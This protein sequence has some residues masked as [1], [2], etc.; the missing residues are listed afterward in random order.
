MY[1][2]SCLLYFLSG[3]HL[4]RPSS[5]FELSPRLW[6]CDLW[7]DPFSQ[8]WRVDWSQSSLKH[9]L[10][11]TAETCFLAACQSNK[12]LHTLE[13]PQTH[14]YYFS[15]TRCCSMQSTS[16]SSALTSPHW[17]S[18]VVK[19]TYF[20]TKGVKAFSWKTN[21][22]KEKQA[23]Y[24]ND[25]IKSCGGYGKSQHSTFNFNEVTESSVKWPSMYYNFWGINMKA[26][27]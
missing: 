8:R 22:N 14:F 17:T 26:V 24:P 10:P 27:Y 4:T 13:S 3:P 19:K 9:R 16:F 15:S 11:N 21:K 7:L 5:C 1:F 12:H 20:L 6:C 23:G 2:T 18:N 25:K